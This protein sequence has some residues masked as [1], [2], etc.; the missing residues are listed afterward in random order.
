VAAFPEGKDF[1]DILEKLGYK[2]VGRKTVSGGIATIYYG[3]K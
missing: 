2:N 1:T 3:I